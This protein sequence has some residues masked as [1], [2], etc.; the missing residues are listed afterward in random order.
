MLGLKN[1]PC[2]WRAGRQLV[3]LRS[4]SLRAFTSHTQVNGARLLRFARSWPS[5]RPARG[6]NIRPPPPRPPSGSYPAKPR[7]PP[8]V[9]HAGCRQIAF[10]TW[11]ETE[12]RPRG[13]SPRKA[14]VSHNRLFSSNSAENRRSDLFLRM[15]ECST[16]APWG[17]SLVDGSGT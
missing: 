13:D 2:I 9:K 12:V 3:P 17:R 8:R 5:A 6:H 11:L 15:P 4:L 7:S 10:T 1:R 14:A 16:K